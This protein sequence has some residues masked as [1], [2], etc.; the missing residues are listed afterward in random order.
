MPRESLPRRARP[1]VPPGQ[2]R[3]QVYNA[4]GT[5]G[6]GTRVSDEL[7]NRGFDVAGPAQNWRRSG[8]TATTIRYDSRYTESIKTVAASLPG[9]RLVS[10]PGLGRTLQVVVGSSWTRHPRGARRDTGRVR[11]RQQRTTHRIRRPLLLTSQSAGPLGAGPQDRLATGEPVGAPDL[12]LLDASPVLGGLR[13]DRRDG[14]RSA[15]LVDRHEDEVRRRHPH[16]LHAGPVPRLGQHPDADLHRRGA[17]PV[18][19]GLGVHQV[20]DPHRREEGHLVHRRGDG[21]AAGVPLRHHTGDVVDQ[22]HD[23]AAVHGAQQVGVQDGH[24]PAQPAARCAGGPAGA[25]VQVTLVTVVTTVSGGARL[26]HS[27]RGY[28]RPP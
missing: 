14:A 4:V 20:A 12:G 19:L 3:V 8:V 17:R 11:Q 28:G 18:H 2:V 13:Q 21:S 23:H 15:L 26:A 6:L 22:L 25:L 16:G 27:Q 9:A 7:A 5:P 24:D 10:V 1:T